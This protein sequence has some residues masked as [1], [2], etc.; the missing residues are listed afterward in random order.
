MSTANSRSPASA[1]FSRMPTPTASKRSRGS[2]SG[3][4]ADDDDGG[5]SESA[6]HRRKKRVPQ[7]CTE[8]VRRK[9]KCDR[10]QPCSACIRRKRTQ[11]CVF[12]DEEA[13]SPWALATDVKAIQRR[14]AQLE[15]LVHSQERS[16]EY[17]ARQPKQ[18]P[19]AHNASFAPHRR[20]DRQS[21]DPHSDTESAVV[22]L[23]DVAFSSRVPVLRAINAA[24]H[25]HAPGTYRYNASGPLASAE[26]TDARTSILAE[27]LTFDQDGRPRSAVRLGLDLAVSTVD[28]P[29]FRREALGQ[30]LAVLPGIEISQFLIAKYF[31]EI[32]WDYK[33]LDPVAFPLEYLRYT[34]MLANGREDLIDPLWI[35]TF[36]MVLAL[37]LEGFWSR[38]HGM[39]D[40]SLF[41]GLDEEGLKDLPSVWHDA[42]LRALQLGEYGGTPRIRAIQCIILF[43]QYIQVFSSSGQTGRFL[44]WFASAVR[45]AQRMGLHRLGTD[46]RTMPP[47]DPALPPGTNSFKREMAVR[48]FHHLV[49][50]DSFLSDSPCCR[51]Y[52]LHPTQYNTARP[53]NL[54]LSELSRTDNIAVEQYPGDVYTE[55]SYQIVQCRIAEQ[56]RAA[57]ENLVLAEDSFSYPAVV[58]QDR[59]FQAILDTDVPRSFAW[60][61]SI[62]LDSARTAYERACLHEEL[63][64]R[65]V[66]LNRPLLG[67]GYHPNSPY[68]H[69]TAQCIEFSRRLIASNY[70]LLRLSPSLWL[71]YTG[72]LASALVLLMDMFHAIDTDEDAA[73][74]RQKREIL[75]KAKLIFDTKVATPALEVVVE[76]GRK[77]LAA[78]F[79][80]E[81]SRRTTRAAFDMLPT[82]SAPPALES[83]AQVLKRITREV[84][85][86]AS[87]PFSQ[88]DRSSLSAIRPMDPISTAFGTSIPSFARSAAGAMTTSMT[89][90]HPG[91]NPVEAD[92]PFVGD[93]SNFM[94]TLTSEDWTTFGSPE[95]GVLLGQHSASW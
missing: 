67:R 75:Q 7:S 58:K 4:K 82:S 12:E 77:I 52:L 37:S 61:S 40:L 38:P 59:A 15:S 5:G 65:I 29:A 83:F 62:P 25:G 90:G 2:T 78:L 26:L 74:L 16:G 70:E 51:C 22:E 18:P 85:A 20:T 30:I 63:S 19:Q 46:L 41:R 68:Q 66:R 54:N 91:A 95:S 94:G 45:V 17:A 43:G 48:L 87:Q 92:S 93:L 36:C 3:S 9:I 53:R 76:E 84:A 72:T 35:A 8:C 64:A 56:V 14:L 1:D 60:D 24:S 44:G 33:V 49:N 13:E 47:D 32:E 6:S 10:E 71:T 80:A 28:L 79:A 55:A 57:L 27:P 21:D 23:E 89:G 86:Q 88:A 39:K 73:T 69:S 11:F 42:A 34:E 81:E 31:A 50:I